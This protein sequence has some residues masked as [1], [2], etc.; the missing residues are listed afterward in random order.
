[1]TLL[2]ESFEVSDIKFAND[3]KVTYKGRT[4][5]LASIPSGSTAAITQSGIDIASPSG[6]KLD[7][8]NLGSVCSRLSFKF[9]NF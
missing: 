9:N 4:Y 2:G 3:G 8:S 5:D 6:S 7:V 1:M